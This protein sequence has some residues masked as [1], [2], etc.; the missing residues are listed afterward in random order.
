MKN[1]RTNEPLRGMTEEDVTK[2][3]ICLTYC[4]VSPFEITVDFVITDEVF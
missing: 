1:I 3:L 4:H 2:D